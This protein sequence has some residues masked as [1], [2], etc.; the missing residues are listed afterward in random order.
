MEF[1][2]LGAIDIMMVRHSIFADLNLAGSTGPHSIGKQKRGFNQPAQVLHMAAWKQQV[3]IPV[4]IQI[5]GPDPQELC[6]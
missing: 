6:K 2:D 4:A 1:H 5:K 3:L